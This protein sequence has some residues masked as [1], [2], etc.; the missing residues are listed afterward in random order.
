MKSDKD[1][2]IKITPNA[3]TRIKTMTADGEFKGMIFRV[4]VLGG[5]CSGFQYNFSFE[6]KEKP[7]DKIIKQGGIKVV[8]DEVSWNYLLGSE[9][10]F[11]EELVGS[12]F[13]IRNPNAASTC[14]CG[15]S[16]SI[17]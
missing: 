16:F 6:N 2:E 17:G 15:V 1:H 8:I 14:G 5:G 12:F 4:E 9:I 7:D 13:T 10:H 11:A 3:I